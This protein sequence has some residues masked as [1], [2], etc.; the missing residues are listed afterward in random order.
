[1]KSKILGALIAAVFCPL[2]SA[3][4]TVS[5][6]IK[7]LGGTSANNS[8]VRFWLRGCN[9][10]Q[11]RVNGVAIVPSNTNGHWHLSVGR[12]DYQRRWQNIWLEGKGMP[13]YN[14]A[15]A[16]TA[17]TGG[18][19]FTGPI[20]VIQGGDHFVIRNAG[21]D[22]GVTWTNASNGGVATEGLGH[23]QQR[24]SSRSAAGA[25]SNH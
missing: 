4:T 13:N 5:G 14:S 22:T 10:N 20:Q 12:R 25:V 19:I 21:V 8:F 3:T 1:M 16:P 11:P 2:L 18:T 6:S 7:T 23:L 15:T 24:P 9:G 17:L